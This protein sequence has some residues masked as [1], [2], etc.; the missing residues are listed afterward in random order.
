MNGID[1]ALNTNKS[2]N[3]PAGEKQELKIL[4][5]FRALVIME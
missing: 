3:L 2:F 1:D 5:N 4:E